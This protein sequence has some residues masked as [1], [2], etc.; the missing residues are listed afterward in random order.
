V[1]D[2]EFEFS[3]PQNRSEKEITKALSKM[4]VFQ[5]AA[6]KHSKKRL[7]TWAIDCILMLWQH[8]QC[9][10][11]DLR[12]MRTGDPFKFKF[13]T[14]NSATGYGSWIICGDNDEVFASMKN[15]STKIGAS[16]RVPLHDRC[17]ELAKFLKLWYQVMK[18][19]QG[20][21]EPFLACRITTFKAKRTPMNGRSDAQ[22]ANKRA[23]LSAGMSDASQNMTRVASSRK[24]REGPNRSEETLHNAGQ[25]QNYQNH[26]PKRPRVEAE[27]L[28]EPDWDQFRCPAPGV[29]IHTRFN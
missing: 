9:D 20:T 6:R 8:G 13:A 24:T 12:P 15:S 11:A 21:D 29:C 16:A 4:H 19:Y 26:V 14:V 5:L 10:D 28:T 22:N 3:F 7:G 27:D 2:I 18:V 23:F 17:P 1:K 25:E